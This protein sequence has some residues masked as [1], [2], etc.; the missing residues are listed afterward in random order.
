MGES[1]KRKFMYSVS[2]DPADLGSAFATLVWMQS[3]TFGQPETSEFE[4]NRLLIDADDLTSLDQQTLESPYRL[5][6]ASRLPRTPAALKRWA[7]KR[8]LRGLDAVARIRLM[9]LYGIPYLKRTAD[10]L[11]ELHK[12]DPQLVTYLLEGRIGSAIRHVPAQGYPDDD[13]DEKSWPLERVLAVIAIV[14]KLWIANDLQLEAAATHVRIFRSTGC[15][16]LDY[17]ANGWPVLQATLIARIERELELY[18]E[19]K[20][21]Y[22]GESKEGS[23]ESL[24]PRTATAGASLSA[25]SFRFVLRWPGSEPRQL[26][27]DATRAE[28]AIF[29]GPLRLRAQLA[30]AQWRRAH[31]DELE[32]YIAFRIRDAELRMKKLKRELD[33]I[34]ADETLKRQRAHVQKGEA[35]LT[36]LWLACLAAARW[37]EWI[38]APRAVRDKHGEVV[39][40][41]GK[42][43]ADEAVWSIRR[44]NDLKLPKEQDHHRAVARELFFALRC[45][46][47]R[48]PEHLP[49][50]LRIVTTEAGQRVETKRRENAERLRGRAFTFREIHAHQ[51]AR[52]AGL[53]NSKE[54]YS[55]AFITPAHDFLKAFRKRP[56]A[57]GRAVIQKAAGTAPWRLIQ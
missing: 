2:G 46:I 33:A 7:A 17:T 41:Y 21:L 23:D 5:Y 25:D 14:L 32:E 19:A 45:T 40:V 57:E 9:N 22:E 44:G 56:S 26:R 1:M 43:F 50:G 38:R 28:A 8:I 42:D 12:R 47:V 30:L 29:A 36:R 10:C 48:D 37:V 54:V 16:V 35:P 4:I 6:D 34:R 18:F 39:G 3:E 20:R 53:R 13:D 52:Y 49:S 27:R 11:Y 51:E 24:A 55:H 15:D 31:G